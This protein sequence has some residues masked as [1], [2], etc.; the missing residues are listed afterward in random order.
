MNLILKTVGLNSAQIKRIWGGKP[1]YRNIVAT[2]WFSKHSIEH[3][4]GGDEAGNI[5]T[6][7][8]HDVLEFS[9]MTYDPS[10]GEESATPAT[11]ARALWNDYTPTDPTVK[12]RVEPVTNWNH[13]IWVER[14]P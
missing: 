14:S 13:S 11:W 9:G 2:S 1:G 6:Y 4:K 10:Y 7:L 3:L 5:A 8:F 12:V